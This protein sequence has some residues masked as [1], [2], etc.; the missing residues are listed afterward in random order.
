MSYFIAKMLQIRLRLGVCLKTL[1]GELTVLP[2]PTSWIKRGLLLRGRRG[3]KGPNER[4][5]S[6]REGKGEGARHCLAR[7]LAS[8]C[9]ATG[10]K[11]S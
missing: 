9:N 6:V 7:P 3:R 1:L 11:T 5:E 10:S 4:G 8:L 2:R